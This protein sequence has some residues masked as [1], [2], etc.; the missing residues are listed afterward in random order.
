MKEIIK[1]KPLTPEQE[2]MTYSKYYYEELAEIPEEK[3]KIIASGPCD[4]K[5]ALKIQEMNKIFDEG[6]LD[7]EIGYCQMED[8]TGFVANKTFMPE[9]TGEMFA[10]WFAWHSLEDLRYKIWD[11]EDHIYA[12][13][14]TPERILDQSVPVLE[15]N[16]GTTHDIVED[17]GF[18]EDELRIHFM[19]PEEMG[20]DKSKI[21]TKYCSAIQTGNAEGPGLNAVM[22]HMVRDVEGGVELRSRFWIGYHIKD[23]KPV[24]LLPDGAKVPIIA[25]ENLFKHNCV[26]FTNL[27]ELLPRVYAEEKDNW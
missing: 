17:V 1:R 26:E 22:L 21:F 4:P 10:W 25:P 8:G 13:N 14:Q 19:D 3:K 16:W 2:K 15:R 20:L 12:R 7:V 9:V 27:A 24:K 23:K 18:G 6:Y 5:K 11:P